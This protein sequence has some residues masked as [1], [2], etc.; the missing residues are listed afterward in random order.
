MAARP[1]AYRIYSYSALIGE[2]PKRR[3]TPM[4]Q[5]REE[6]RCKL[7]V[8]AGDRG[9]CGSFNSNIFKRA[10][11]FLAEKKAAGIEVQIETIGKKAQ[12]YFQKRYGVAHYYEGL[13]SKPEYKTTQEIATKLLEHYQDDQFDATYLLYNEF[14][15][16][17][18]QTVTV[19]KLIP[20]S[21]EVPEGVVG[22]RENSGEGDA[23]V[24]YIY[25][26]SRQELLEAV[27][28][29]HFQVQLYRAVLESVAAEHGAR[30]SAMDSATK[31]ANEMVDK[32]TLDYNKARQAAITTELSE[33]VGGVE[34]MK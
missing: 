24:E 4:L 33:I 31:N 28:P 15:S 34:A 1:Y 17:I 16:A 3:P 22:I 12:E 18:Q 8:L 26:P 29:R 7:I 5:E 30:M 25:E 19:E 9:L 11:A 27:V 21:T 23:A 32:L 14:K 2:G 10:E 6:K 13:I 20:V